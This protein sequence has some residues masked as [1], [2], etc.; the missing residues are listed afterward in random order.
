MVFGMIYFYFFI[1]LYKTIK[2]RM[3]T[4]TKRN[5][6]KEFTIDTIGP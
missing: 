3:K 2:Y 6:K 5:M 4:E 1:S